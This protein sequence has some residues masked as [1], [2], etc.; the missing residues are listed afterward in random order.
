M[1]ES[2]DPNPDVMFH[3][4][5]VVITGNREEAKRLL[6]STNVERLPN[7]LLFDLHELAK[8]P[9]KTLMLSLVRTSAFFPAWVQFVGQRAVLLFP[10]ISFWVL[11][12]T[13]L[14][15]RWF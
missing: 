5:S 6:V 9:S 3:A 2:D 11:R 13:R 1:N 12:K 7:A 14:H 10:R 15:H 8:E 4:C